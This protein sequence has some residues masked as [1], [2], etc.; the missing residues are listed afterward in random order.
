MAYSNLILVVSACAQQS[1]RYCYFKKRAK[2]KLVLSHSMCGFLCALKNANKG[3]NNLDSWVISK[4]AVALERGWLAKKAF[5][6]CYCWPTSTTTMT[7]SLLSAVTKRSRES[8][9]CKK[10]VA[11]NSRLTSTAARSAAVAVK[12]EEEEESAS[13]FFLCHFLPSWWQCS[14]IWRSLFIGGFLRAGR[15]FRCS[16]PT[17]TLVSFF[18]NDFSSLH[19]GN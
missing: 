14:R 8:R 4:N 7:S 15:D 5:A 18:M 11:K 9:G 16:R 12:G 2:F 6:H 3:V 13:T 19:K 1:A 17:L 10:R